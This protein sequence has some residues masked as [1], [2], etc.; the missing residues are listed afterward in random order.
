MTKSS[1]APLSAPTSHKITD[2]LWL[3]RL[4]AGG[5]PATN[6]APA[7]LPTHHIVW[8]DAS[9]SMYSD[10]PNIR[11]TLKT[12]LA[13]MVGE[14]DLVT[15]G[16]F[17]GPR[18]CDVLFEAEPVRTLT[19]LTRLH[20][21]IDKLETVGCTCFVDPIKM[22]SSVVDRVRKTHPKH[23]ASGLF[24]SDG[25]HNAG[26]SI[27]DVIRACDAAAGGFASFATVGYGWYAGM[28]LLMQMAERFGG[29]AIQAKDFAA[30]EPTLAGILGR[31]PTGA[32]CAAVE[33]AGEAIGGFAFAVSGGDLLTWA[34]ES[35]KANVPTDVPEIWYLSAKQQ[36]A[37]D[38]DLPLC[39]RIALQADVEQGRK[40]PLFAAAYAAVSLFSRRIQ[41]KIVKPILRALGD[42]SLAN[43]YAL[44]FGKQRT[45]AYADLA[46]AAALGNGR[47][48]GGYD[49]NCVPKPDAFTVLDLLA[50]LAN[51]GCHFH[52][53]HEAFVYK[54]I[55][56]AR[57][58]ASDVINDDD[59]AGIS[60][61]SAADV[62]AQ[63]DAIRAAK[64]TPLKFVADAAPDGYAI[65]GIVPASETP[66]VSI[67]VLRT[68]HVDLSNRIAALSTKHAA[69]VAANDV[70]TAQAIHDDI[71]RSASLPRIFPTKTF[72][73]YAV[74]ADGIVNVERLPVTLTREAWKI[75][76]AEGIVKGSYSDAVQVIDLT[77][78]P[79][80]NERMVST[81][82][83]Q[84]TL[85]KAYRLERVQAAQKV[86][87]HYIKA[88]FPPA[89]SK[90]I[91]DVYGAEAAV[92]LKAQGLTD[93]GFSPSSTQAESTDVR[94]VRYMEVTF[95]GLSSLPKVDDA[96]AK[97]L[98]TVKGKQTAGGAIMEPAMRSMD[99]LLTA[100][101][102][103]YADLEAFAAGKA[104]DD[105]KATA[106]KIAAAMH[107][108]NDLLDEERRA[109]LMDLARS[110][111]TVIVG[112]AWFKEWGEDFGEVDAKEQA[113]GYVAKKT[114]TIN[115]DGATVEGTIRM[116]EVEEKI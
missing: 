59:L 35:G 86:W 52:P 74:I 68:G 47:Y 2:D 106:P 94:L 3:V 63:L 78:L 14:H 27:A 4:T 81:L 67:R 85:E 114:M 39:T 104:T 37:A 30:W 44:C 8:V 49:A 115:V 107:A 1:K 62:Q 36:G 18:Q 33:I 113:K 38:N 112:P 46:A 66:N 40:H 19:D 58:D 17:S 92:W 100:H 51:T 20:R 32:P 102:V 23:V 91:G 76:A 41:A 111:F 7:P 75:L 31:K 50:T 96:R 98:G 88:Y 45:A 16:W 10:L 42:V 13:T 109:L 26:G 12:K 43:G 95:A 65:N 53:D 54:R 87:K 84:F 6:A 28:R 101:K 25:E 48:V 15:V 5:A 71:A 80:I 72:R 116:R 90:G 61:G 73:N 55:G 97:M 105:V 57:L 89:S 9:G 34:V 70:A 103:D 29:S 22:M 56:R 79:V 108:Q 69:A 11:R 99:A 110:A 93:N 24:L 60:A 82:S 77:A 64:G 21:A 83:A